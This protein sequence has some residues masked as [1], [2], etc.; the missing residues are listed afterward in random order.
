MEPAMVTVVT[1]A[2][3]AVG[4]VLGAWIGG[5][6]RRQPAQENSRREDASYLGLDQGQEPLGARPRASCQ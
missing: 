6:S 1:A 3:S 2:I 4:T 5:R